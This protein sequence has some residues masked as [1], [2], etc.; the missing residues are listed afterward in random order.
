MRIVCRLLLAIKVE[1]NA[2]CP[3]ASSR[4]RVLLLRCPAQHMDTQL[5]PHAMFGT[6]THLQVVGRQHLEEAHRPRALHIQ[7]LCTPNVSAARVQQ[8]QQRAG[9]PRVRR[10]CRGPGASP[11]TTLARPSHLWQQSPAGL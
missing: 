9:A 3:D 10:G 8:Q 11:A 4:P 7:A 2:G 1:G 6:R 5:Q